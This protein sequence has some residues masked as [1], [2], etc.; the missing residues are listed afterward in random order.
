[1]IN[2]S[3][4]K[5]IIFDF[6]GVIININPKLT[7]NALK[8]LGIYNAERAFA[9]IKVSSILYDL[10]IGKLSKNEFLHYIKNL[11]KKDI[12]FNQII[13][14]W[15]KMI[16]DIPKERIDLLTEVKKYYNIYLLSNT[17]TI[18][19][20]YFNPLFL[21]ATGGVPF[22]KFFNKAYFS[23]EIKMRKPGI[24]I[25]K[26][27]LNDTK[28]LPTETLFIDDSIENIETANLLG[29]K[30][31]WLTSDLVSVFNQISLKSNH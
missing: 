22:Q 13:D 27:L 16:L 11:S 5:N 21:S 28:I 29:F 19:Y 26:F 1:M 3:E 17:N 23:F 31:I 2:L 4:I 30:T 9:N 8:E 7:I 25:F 20:N 12:T 24:E 14:A 6:G 18:H 15:N 10:E